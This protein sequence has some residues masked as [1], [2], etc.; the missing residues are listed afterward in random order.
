MSHPFSEIVIEGP[1]MLVKGFLVGFLSAAKPDGKYFFHR[2]AGIHR[3]T[4]KGF[5]KELF[6][7]DNHVHLCIETALVDRFVESAKLYSEITGMKIQS[8]K[9]INTA[10]FSFAY[11]LYNEDIAA[12]AKKLISNISEGVKVV[13]YLPVE[14]KDISGAGVEAYAP[15]HEFTSRAKGTITGDFEGVIDLYLKI[16]RGDLSESIICSEVR[17]VLD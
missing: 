3:E 2:K 8:V 1:F 7:L 5:L 14:E 6:E 16:K 9:P 17:L 10:G 11:E 4:L 15:L 13:D 12:K